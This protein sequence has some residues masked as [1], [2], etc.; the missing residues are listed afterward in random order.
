MATAA[1]DRLARTLRGDMQTAF[2]VQLTAKTDD[3]SLE[4][5]GFGHV[6]FPVTPAKARK[7]LGLGQPARFGRGEETVTDPDVRDTWEI[8]K[9]LVRAEWND[10][11]L[12]DVLATVKEELGLPNAAELTADLHSLLVYETNQHFLAHQDSE[13]DDSMVGTLVVTLPSNFAGG[14]LMVGHNEEW[15]AYR[16]SKTALSLVAFYA[17]CRHEVLKVTSGYRITLTYN[18]LLHGDTS[19]PPGEDGTVAELADLLREHFSTSVSRYYGG[20]AADPPNRL[21]YLLD[22][23]YTPRGLSWRRLKGADASRVALLRTAADQAACE[24]VLALADVKTTHSAFPADE[25][26]GYG[27]RRDWYDEY[28]DD[29]DEQSGSEGEYEIQEIIDSEV[30]LTH[31]TGPDGTRLEE[32]S[33]FA[34]QDQVCASTPE[35]GLE[36]Y[37]SEYE[38]Y[39]GNWGNTLDR[40]YH[41]AAVVVWPRDQAFANRAETSPAWALGELTAMASAGDVSGAQAAAATLAPF[42]DR[43]LRARTAELVGK[44]LRAADAVAD[45]GTAAMLLHPFRI[46]NLTRADVGSFGKIVGKYGPQWT[47]DLLRTWFGGDQPAWTYGGGAER[48]QWVAD[49][50]PGVCQKLHVRG[51]AGAVAAQRLLDLAWEWTS[52]DIGTGLA[53]P[54]PSH[55]D[56]KLGDLGK[57]LASVLTAAA[58]TGAAS[59]RDAVCRYIRKQEDAVTALEMSALRAA[60]QMSRDR[61]RGDAGVGDLAVDCAAR[62]RA[63]LARPQRAPGDWS[64]ELPA[65]GC[66]CDLCGT[67]RAFLE[68]QSRRTFDWPLAQQRRQHVHSRI[69]AAELP[70]THVTR[71]R[72][73]PYTLVLNKTEALFAREREARIRDETDLEWLAAQW[74][75]GA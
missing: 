16:G 72:G 47:A 61:T 19:R 68:D 52:K 8:P 13:K 33:L 53:S 74:N 63:R 29:D 36:P 40:W 10:A 73:S 18:L 20:P 69:D 50:L 22:H 25:S 37:S 4:V 49:R 34:G 26:Y 48:P 21:V 67:L 44:A 71:R 70:V 54:S 1:R 58:A 75:P 31:W 12:K 7:L 42:W 46:E 55:R 17:D 59:T 14:E 51:G 65:D 60:A 15:K 45:A 32:T 23:E 30:T 28:G 64:I 3:L 24:A 66:T 5:E 27:R 41:R 57:P 39:M 35:G 56:T 6:K 9:H 2:S 62:L 43:A 38:G 11:T